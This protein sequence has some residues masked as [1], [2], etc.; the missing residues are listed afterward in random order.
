MTSI[1]QKSIP[2]WVAVVVAVVLGAICFSVIHSW[3]AIVVYGVLVLGIAVIY[4]VVSART[5]G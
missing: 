4:R 1:N 5:R 2:G 3:W